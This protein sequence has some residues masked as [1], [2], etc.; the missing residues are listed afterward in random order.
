MIWYVY[1][2]SGFSPIPDPGS[3]TLPNCC[4]LLAG[5]LP[6]LY[7]GTNAEF[8]KADSVIFR[9]DLYDLSSGLI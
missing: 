3:A 1:P 4:C 8:S 5:G 6:G 2:G 7:S 9:T